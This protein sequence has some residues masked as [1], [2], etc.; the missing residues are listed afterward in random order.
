[1][2]HL[3]HC[4]DDKT[5]LLRS[6]DAV[7]A[8]GLRL[9][10]ALGFASDATCLNSYLGWEQEFFV[11]S[12]DLYKQRPDLINCGRTLIGKLPNRNQQ[13]DL[14][15]FAPVPSK[16]DNLLKELRSEVKRKL[17]MREAK[18]DADHEGFC[19]TEIGKSKVTRTR[20]QEEIDALDA[21]V[22]DGKATILELTK[23]T[24]ELT[25][26]VADLVAARKE[27]TKELLSAKGEAATQKAEKQL[28]KAYKRQAVRW[29]RPS[30]RRRGPPRGNS[31]L[32]KAAAAA[33]T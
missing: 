18:A 12:A 32:W 5:P 29:Q 7:S 6:Q 3:G 16:V 26:A 17:E 9:L 27:A 10:K 23:S 33:K 22:E 13:M 19:D 30:V 21:A 11:I 8:Q 1:V 2:T 4:I 15:Y 31:R 25:A 24:E 14:N 28:K 20:L